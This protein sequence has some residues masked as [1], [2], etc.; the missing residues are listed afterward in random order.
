MK[1]LNRFIG[2]VLFMCTGWA[3]ALYY[4]VPFTEVKKVYKAA[5]NDLFPF[6]NGV[7]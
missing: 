3:F 1:K 5:F 4:K 2:A 7:K 6:G